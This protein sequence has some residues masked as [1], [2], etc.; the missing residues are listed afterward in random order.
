MLYFLGNCQMDFLSRSVAGLG[1]SVAHFELASPMTH[2]SHPDGV[3]PALASMV[4]EHRLDDAFNGRQPEYQFGRFDV[5]GRENEPPA[6]LVVNLFHETAPLFLHTEDGFIFHMNPAAWRDDPALA[7]RMD[8][9]CRAIAPNPATYLTRFGRFLAL[10]RE[11][12]PATPMLLVTRLGHYPAFGP[13]PYSYL[14]NWAALSR[15]APAHYAVWERELGVRVLDA[16][17]V[18]GGIWRES[19]DGI[20]AHCPFLKIELTERDGAVIGLRA[21]RDVEHVGPLWAGLARKVVAFAEGG[22]IRYAANETVPPEWN[23]PWQPSVLDDE[24]VIDRFAS[25][26]NYPWAEAVGSFFMDLARDRTPLLA[27]SGE[28][29]PVC[30]NT[31][32]MIRAYGRIFKNPL[33]ATFCDTHRPAAEAFTA[34]GPL[35]QADYLARLDE[36]RAHALS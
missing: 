12:F 15:E 36:I 29:M 5:P 25:E 28:F 3:P 18:F 33:L 2:A 19:D 7:A 14:E 30:H 27:A 23:R 21:S 22:E 11:R 32:H 8:A 1:P 9:R 17:R 4:R 10:L 31:L 16:N 24:A 20:E 35:Y 13:A 6:L 26:R 34:N